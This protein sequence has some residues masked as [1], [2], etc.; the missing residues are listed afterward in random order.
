MGH[1]FFISLFLLEFPWLLA[2][3]PEPVTIF[4]RGFRSCAILTPHS[5]YLD[6]AGKP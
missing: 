5:V 4:H 6:P 1:Y 2:K 3:Q